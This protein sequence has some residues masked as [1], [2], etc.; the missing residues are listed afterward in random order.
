M[1]VRVG[2]LSTALPRPADDCYDLFCEVARIPE[3]LSVVRSAMVVRRDFHERPTE[4]AFLARLERATVGYT[5]HYRYEPGRRRVDWSTAPGA[6]LRVAGAASFQP[7]GPSTCL[8]SYQLDLDV[9][10]LP[11][12]SDPM[13]EGHAASASLL[14]FRDFVLRVL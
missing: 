1:P 11:A 2:H 14:D 4:V 13:F 9:G 10:G 8:M 12:W 6:R 7:L 5:C 3:W